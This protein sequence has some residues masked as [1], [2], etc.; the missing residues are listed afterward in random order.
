[1]RLLEC[2]PDAIVG[3][4]FTGNH[5]HVVVQSRA[6]EGMARQSARSGEGLTLKWSCRQSR[7]WKR[8]FEPGGIGEMVKM[9]MQEPRGSGRPDVRTSIGR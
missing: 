6:P 5:R 2:H 8:D 1:V 7:R 3:R 4:Q 9:D